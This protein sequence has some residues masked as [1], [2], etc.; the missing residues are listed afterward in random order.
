MARSALG[1][2]GFLRYFSSHRARLRNRKVCG[3]YTSILEF[4]SLQ[5]RQKAIDAKPSFL[6]DKQSVPVG[7]DAMP[8]NLS[9]VKRCGFNTLFM[10]IYPLWGKDRSLIPEARACE[11]A[12]VQTKGAA[13]VHL[14]LSLFNG[15]FCDVPSRYPGASQ[16]IQCDGTQPSWVCFFDDRL[17]EYYIKNTVEMAKHGA[18][19]PDTLNGIFIHPEA[20]GPEC[21]SSSATMRPQI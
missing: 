6:M 19:V 15:G 13:R 17:W 18:E 5:V 4:D 8:G 3:I 16:T 12:L 9:L 7:S 20:Y 10:T 2:R 11:S 21:Y 1:R 14:G